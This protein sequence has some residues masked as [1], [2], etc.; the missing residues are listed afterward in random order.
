MFVDTI[1]TQ[2]CAFPE[3]KVRHLANAVENLNFDRRNPG[4]DLLFPL[5]ILSFLLP[6]GINHF[7]S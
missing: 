1:K 7:I 4:K 6:E 5:R 2:D 3:F